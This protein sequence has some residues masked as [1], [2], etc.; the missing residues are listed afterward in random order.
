MQIPR[1]SGN[2]GMSRRMRRRRARTGIVAFLL[3]V[4][5]VGL[6]IWQPWKSSDGGKTVGTGTTSP[7]GGSPSG[8]PTVTGKKN[9][10]KHIVFLVKE[11]RTFDN[12]FGKYPGADGAT[13]GKGLTGDASKQITIPLTPGIDEQPH[14]ITHA[15]ASGILSIDGGKMDGFNTILDGTDKS[16]Y[17]VMSSD[18]T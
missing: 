18:C 9:P 13:E 5:V 15:F 3:I 17:S 1:S 6:L 10:I 2:R 16:G 7:S 14:D 11:N 12:Y 8:R 4:A